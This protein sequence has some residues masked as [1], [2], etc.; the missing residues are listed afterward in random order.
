VYRVRGPLHDT[1]RLAHVERE[2]HGGG[3]LGRH[4]H[5]HIL[6]VDRLG[7]IVCDNFYETFSFFY[8]SLYI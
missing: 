7:L 1:E 5:P 8:H 6:Y 3:A 2:G 4:E